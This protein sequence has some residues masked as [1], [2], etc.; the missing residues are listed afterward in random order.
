MPDAEVPDRDEFD[1]WGFLT[2]PRPDWFYHEGHEQAYRIL[3]IFKSGNVDR[4]YFTAVLADAE[5]GAYAGA[6]T[7]HDSNGS[8]L[9]AWDDLD[10]PTEYNFVTE[11][12][13]DP[14]TPRTHGL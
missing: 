5:T 10:D 11:T 8:Y 2:E 13:A 3:D 7:F 4:W 9:T 6:V 14:L 12:D 1:R